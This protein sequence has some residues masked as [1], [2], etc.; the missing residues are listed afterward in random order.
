MTT[1][2][3]AIIGI[4][5]QKRDAAQMRLAEAQRQEAD[6]RHQLADLKGYANDAQAQWSRRALSSTP[7]EVLSGQQGFSDGLFRA[8]DFQQKV[9]EERQSIV[10]RSREALR[11]SEQRLQALEK[12]L[13]LRVRAGHVV[14][15]RREQKFNDEMATQSHLRR[16]A[17]DFRGAQ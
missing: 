10:A 6:A 9:V 3:Q 17:Q 4:L 2:F 15:Q 13:E 12:V 1:A 8:I 7:I 16:Q 11:A 14:K 5:V